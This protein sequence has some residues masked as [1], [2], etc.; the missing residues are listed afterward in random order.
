MPEQEQAKRMRG[1][2]K[3][4]RLIPG[5]VVGLKALGVPTS[6]IAKIRGVTPS[7]VSHVLSR[8]NINQKLLDDYKN[9]KTDIIEGV[10]MRYIDH[11][12][13]AKLKDISPSQAVMVYGTLYDKV[14]LE[15]GQSSINIAYRDMSDDDLLA[16]ISKLT[17][18]I[19]PV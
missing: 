1:K 5:D 13:N 16:E 19:K 17:T 10:S 14:R 4:P 15:K 3:K 8:Y 7:A 9:N 18:M 12:A 11:L 2:D 6:T